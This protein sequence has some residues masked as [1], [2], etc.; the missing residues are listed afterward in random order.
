[1]SDLRQIPD[2]AVPVS[3][4]SRPKA[5][6][7]HRVGD[8][9]VGDLILCDGK[10]RGMAARQGAAPR[11]LILPQSVE[12]HCH[13]DKCHTIDRIGPVAGG[14]QEAIAAQ[15]ADKRN[16]SRADLVRRIARALEEYAAAGCGI[17]R[18]HLDW[19][20]N[21]TPDRLPPAWDILDEQARGQGIGLQIAAL[22]G[23]DMLAA[24][25]V[26]D[27]VAR[28]LAPRD[29]V[30][31]AFVLHQP[32]RMA[33]I[34]AVFAAAERFGLALDFHVDEGLDPGLDGL[35]LIADVALETG[36]QGPVLCGH[37]CSMSLLPPDA[38]ARLADRLARAGITI[39]V[40]PATNLYLQGRHA[41]KTPRPRGI[42]PL[43]ELRAR[44]ARVVIGTDNVRDAFL[45]IG[46]HD[47]L[48]ALSTGCL[49][50]QLDPPFGDWL[51]T[52][53]TDARAALGLAPVTIDG[54]PLAGL[55]AFPAGSTTELLAHPPA[56][57][58]LDEL[59]T[60]SI[61]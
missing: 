60:E 55:R 34:R 32:E 52:I 28:L 51:P 39:A 23:I 56:P 59:I 38:L 22:C 58:R 18:S 19:P 49:A 61:A 2:A 11:A 48:V 9:L 4:L 25:G 36:F 31:G 14:L 10:V 21:P 16:W 43:H 13:L 42:A 26:A 33:G 7:G 3:L 15:E 44:G 12:V 46:R 20:E 30:L 57:T 17:I 6:G 40:L 8:C 5:F 24:P 29:G 47:P 41:G 37:A 1:M 27:T 54:A 35:S 45:P 53:T 50:A